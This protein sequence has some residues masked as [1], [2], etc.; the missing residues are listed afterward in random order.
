[1]KKTILEIKN[2][3]KTYDGKK[4]VLENINLEFS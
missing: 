1:M 3:F 4:N 2:L